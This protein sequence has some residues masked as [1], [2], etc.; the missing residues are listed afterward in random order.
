MICLSLVYF[1]IIGTLK[2]F[3]C[4][5]C[6]IS[7][8]HVSTISA[9]TEGRQY[10][11]QYTDIQHPDGR[12][13]PE[14]SK[15][16]LD[17]NYKCHHC[18]RIY[19]SD[20]RLFYVRHMAELQRRCPNCNGGSGMNNANKNNLDTNATRLSDSLSPGPSEGDPSNAL[21]YLGTSHIRSYTMQAQQCQK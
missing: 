12:Q 5:C 11:E 18:G 7:G 9:G 6:F 8:A 13:T 19:H 1:T 17:E 16:P 3:Q 2:L 21:Q 10:Y 14:S 20:Q 4:I 15:A